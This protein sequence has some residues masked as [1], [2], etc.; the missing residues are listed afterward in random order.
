MKLKADGDAYA[1]RAA[2]DAD[3]EAI[4][5]RGTALGGEN[6]ELIAAN[7]LVD[8][9][10]ALV[11]AAAGS[12]QGSRLTVLNGATGINDIAIGLAAQGLSIYESLRKSMAEE[13]AAIGAS[14]GDKR[15]RATA[16]APP[17]EPA[18]TDS[19]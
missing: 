8:M 2:A 3:A 4:N 9:L 13:T 7:K 10:P 17:A 14:N 11:Q 5:A 1:A 12:M 15:E 6:Q 18:A 16:P 19:A